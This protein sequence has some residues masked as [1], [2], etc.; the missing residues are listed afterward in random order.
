MLRDVC[1]A[2]IYSCNDGVE[3][4][5]A[6]DLSCYFRLAHLGPWIKRAAEGRDI[7]PH[8]HQPP[9]YKHWMHGKIFKSTASIDT[10][11]RFEGDET[12]MKCNLTR[13]KQALP[14]D[15]RSAFEWR[16]RAFQCRTS[17][18]A[19]RII[20]SPP[21]G[22]PSRN[23][24]IQMLPGDSIHKLMVDGQEPR[25]MDECNSRPHPCS[26]E[27]ILNR[28][29]NHTDLQSRRIKDDDDFRVALQGIFYGALLMHGTD[30]RSTYTRDSDDARSYQ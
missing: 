15:E 29:G 18:M 25:W 19:G 14:G 8:C 9:S 23:R 20:L 21:R 24:L 22:P 27:M 5:V 7:A 10:S 28:M 12:I 1:V 6:I 30:L 16:S 17:S 13:E 11:G 26:D 2:I 3:Q 4:S